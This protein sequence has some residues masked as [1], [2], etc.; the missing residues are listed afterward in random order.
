M[1]GFAGRVKESLSGGQ[2]VNDMV[3][4][5]P[6]VALA[7]FAARRHQPA[8]SQAGEMLRDGCLRSAGE[9]DQVGYPVLAVEQRE[10]NAEASRIREAVEEPSR[11]LGFGGAQLKHRHLTMI[12][13]YADESR[14][15]CLGVD[16]R[17]VPSSRA[18][19]T[20]GRRPP[21]AERSSS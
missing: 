13:E 1:Y 10:K 21:T 15:P 12:A 6:I 14:A 3:R 11:G 7:A 20:V 16:A 2:D 17:R 19:R 8:R 18:V 5:E 9:P 4:G